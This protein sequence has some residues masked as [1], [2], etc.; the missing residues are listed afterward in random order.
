MFPYHIPVYHPEDPL[1]M[2]PLYTYLLT[3]EIPREMEDRVPRSYCYL[4]VCPSMSLVLQFLKLICS[5]G[6]T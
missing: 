2:K 4:Y 1:E 6:N 5:I 3:E